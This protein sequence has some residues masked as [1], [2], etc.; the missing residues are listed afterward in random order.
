VIT[1]RAMPASPIPTDPSLAERRWEGPRCW[2]GSTTDQLM[3]TYAELDELMVSLGREINR[4]QR[5]LQAVA[6]P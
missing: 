2:I 4:R 3:E 6:S 1:V 5:A